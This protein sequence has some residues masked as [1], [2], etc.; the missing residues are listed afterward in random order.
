MSRPTLPI[1]ELFLY[2]LLVLVSAQAGFIYGAHYPVVP[3]LESI[4]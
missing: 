3:V 4:K 2:L 1:K